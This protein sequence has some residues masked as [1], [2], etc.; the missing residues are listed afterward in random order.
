MACFTVGHLTLEA[1]G[2]DTFGPVHLFELILPVTAIVIATLARAEEDGKRL[3]GARPWALFAASTLLALSFYTPLRF[4]SARAITSHVRAPWD[5]TR[6]LEHAIVYVPH[7]QF[8]PMCGAERPYAVLYHRPNPDPWLLDPV[9]FANHLTIEEDRIH[10]ESRFAD[11]SAWVLQHDEHC[12]VV[13]VP[14]HDPAANAI[15][16]GLQ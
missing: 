6:H 8:H 2:I 4:A 3:L 15:Q 14:L 1:P 7:L 12:N 10:H 16:P 13:L 9:L 5:A 11:R